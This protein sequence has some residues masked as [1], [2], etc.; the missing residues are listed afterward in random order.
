[1]ALI[2]ATLFPVFLHSVELVATV[3]VRQRG[4]ASVLAQQEPGRPETRNALAALVAAE[5][6]RIYATL[7]AEVDKKLLILGLSDKFQIFE[8]IRCSTRIIKIVAD[9]WRARRIRLWVVNF[10]VDK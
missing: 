2:L 4:K 6:V 5:Q 8:P 3:K 1:M 10:M 9:N 7:A